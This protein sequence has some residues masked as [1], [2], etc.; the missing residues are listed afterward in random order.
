MF[1]II[2]VLLILMWFLIIYH[3]LIYP[4]VLQQL[5]RHHQENETELDAVSNMQKKP[6]IC[7][8]IPA[9]NEADVIADKIRN[10]ASLEYPADKFKVVIACDGCTDQTAAI[11]RHCAQEIENSQLDITIIELPQNRGKVFV[12]NMMIDCLND[13]VI[14]LSD[15]SALI[16][17]DALSIAAKHFK[18]PNVAVVG[19][20]YQFLQA[21]NCG[22]DAYW[23]Y[24]RKIKLAEAALGNPIGV[25]G[26]LYLFRRHL[27]EPL[28]ADTINDDFILPMAIV[29]HGFHA[30]YEPTM[31]ALELEQ[32]SRQ[33]DQ[34]RRVR[35]GAGNLQQLLRLPQL[36]APS[37]GWTAFNFFSGKALR[38]VMPLLIMLQLLL[39]LAL[40]TQ[41]FELLLFALLQIAGF[42]CAWLSSYLPEQKINKYLNILFYLANG[43]RCSLLGS[44]RYLLGLERGCWKSIDPKH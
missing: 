13:E 27:F 22:E 25:H 41:S 16:S 44:L 38:A 5:H 32:A 34:Q 14:A 30:I 29:S 37:M 43:Y 21:G 2:F 26:A 9:Y 24:Q 15:A 36:L 40:A 18:D 6:S 19:A 4:V 39:C 35:L 12:L 3:H 23:Q 42:I 20:G 7:V 11:A 28:P 10:L 31:V 8:L 17:I 1:I 33:M